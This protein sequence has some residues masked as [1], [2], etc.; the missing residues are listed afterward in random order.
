MFPLS[1]QSLSQL[2]LDKIKTELSRFL[3]E[4]INSILDSV[5]NADGPTNSQSSSMSDLIR[6]FHE[7]YSTG[8]RDEAE[9]WSFCSQVLR[10][11]S[12]TNG[13]AKI[14]AQSTRSSSKSDNVSKTSPQVHVNRHGSIS[15]S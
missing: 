1:H 7:L 11:P 10:E 13:C 8:S 4:E 9:L 14:I 5:V 6:T 15:I 2:T 3:S 12:I